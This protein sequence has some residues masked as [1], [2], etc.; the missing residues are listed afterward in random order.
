MVPRLV[1][2]LDEED[3]RLVLERRVGVGIHVVQDL[4]QVVHL[5]GDGGRVGTHLPLAEAAAE[6]RGGR[7]GERIGPVG[8]VELNGAEQHVD[9]ALPRAGDEVVLEVEMVVG[10]QVAGAVGRLPVAPEGE[11]QAVPAHPGEVGHVLVDHQLAVAVNITRRP[12]VGGGGEHVVRAE[13]GH[14][15]AIVLPADHPGA[16]EVDGAGGGRGSGGR[17]GLRLRRGR[18]D[19]GVEEETGAEKSTHRL[20]HRAAGIAAGGWPRIA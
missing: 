10:D 19:Q 5:R 7:V 13:E 1:H 20:P 3:R 8:A 4:A 17:C 16:V 12:V 15:L 9:P 2:Q 11:P 6:A 14:F 18:N